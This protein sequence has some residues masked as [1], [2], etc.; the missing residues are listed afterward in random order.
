M[1]IRSY[2]LDPVPS[3]QTFLPHTLTHMLTNNYIRII[4]AW[5]SKLETLP[6]FS[7]NLC[8]ILAIVIMGKI[9]SLMTL[10]LRSIYDNIKIDM[11]S[12]SNDKGNPSIKRDECVIAFERKCDTRLWAPVSV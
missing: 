8:Y 9:A 11:L 7:P 10:N 12:A 5:L 4:I 1:K 2:G 3:N 6:P